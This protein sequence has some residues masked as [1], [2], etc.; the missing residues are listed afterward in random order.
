[1]SLSGPLA[2]KKDFIRK[3]LEPKGV[4]VHSVFNR[5]TASAIS[6]YDFMWDTPTVNPLMDVIAIT[7]SDYFDGYVVSVVQSTLKTEKLVTVKGRTP[8]TRFRHSARV[9]VLIEVGD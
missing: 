2:G 9:E 5:S 3:L 7:L 1:M 8:K 4:K 6:Y